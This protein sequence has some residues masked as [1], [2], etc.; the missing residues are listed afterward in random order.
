VIEQGKVGVLEVDGA[1]WHPPA[2][3]DEHHE[4]DRRIKEHGVA[5]VERYAADQCTAMPDDVVASFL[6]LLATIG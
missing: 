4:S 6:R 5:V 1:P 2:R 3:A